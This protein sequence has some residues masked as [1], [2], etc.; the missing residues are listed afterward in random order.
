MKKTLSVKDLIT[1]R[2]NKS[3]KSGDLVSEG[4]GIHDQPAMT[5]K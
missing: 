1:H 4:G 2:T 5:E 3:K